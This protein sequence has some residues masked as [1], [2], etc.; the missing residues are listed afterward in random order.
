MSLYSNTNSDN[1]ITAFATHSSPSGR[2]SL[3]SS[4]SAKLHSLISTSLSDQVALIAYQIT[5]TETIWTDAGSGADRDFSSNRANEPTGYYS[6]GDIGVATHSK[7]SF[8]IVVKERK[9]GALAAPTGYRQRWNDGGSGADDDVAFYEPICP[10]GYRVLGYVTIRS[11]NH[12]PS[13]S[14]V[15]CVKKDVLCCGGEM[16]ICV[17]RFW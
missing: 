1:G 9:T 3:L 13:T 7:P 15:R 17:G 2:P 5:E 12:Q 10:P 16:E 4:A 8:S 6:L 14:D 11:H